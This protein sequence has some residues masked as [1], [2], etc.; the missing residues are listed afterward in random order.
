MG[1]A[2][3]RRRLHQLC[4][5]VVPAPPPRHH[6]GCT[7]TP[8]AGYEH[9][10]HRGGET[11]SCGSVR[12]YCAQHGGEARAR[13]EVD[14]SYPRCWHTLAPASVSRQD[15]DDV[16]LMGLM[17]EHAYVVVRPHHQEGFPTGH[18]KVA[19]GIG[20]H[21]T[22]MRGSWASAE[23]AERA[24]LEAWRR[25][26]DRRLEDLRRL[27]GGTLGWGFP[28]EPLRRPHVLRLEPGAV[29]WEAV[30]QV[31]PPSPAAADAPL[32]VGLN[33]RERRALRKARAR[34]H[35][36]RDERASLLAAVERARVEAVPFPDEA[37][38][39]VAATREEAP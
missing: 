7:R 22:E 33:S 25:Q 29:A 4:C 21:T 9:E 20:S 13:E 38:L 35:L 30:D 10:H 16:G 11:Y 5:E 23:L 24:G 8:A 31:S 14:A 1:C 18:W 28:V 27:R 12:A 15:V 2:V 26:L 17:S 37:E 39:R 36:Y 34:E 19:L 3:I 32:E 6:E